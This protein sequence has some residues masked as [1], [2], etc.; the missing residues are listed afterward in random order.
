[1]C[2]YMMF[3]QR[4]CGAWKAKSHEHFFTR[5]KPQRAGVS[6]MAKRVRH[7]GRNT[8]GARGELDKRKVLEDAELPKLGGVRLRGCCYYPTIKNSEWKTRTIVLQYF[9]IVQMIQWKQRIIVHYLYST[10]R[11]MRILRIVEN[12]QGAD[13]RGVGGLCGML[14]W[15]YL[16]PQT[17]DKRKRLP[18]QNSKGVCVKTKDIPT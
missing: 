5:K 1:M 4:G 17:P 7:H 3:N 2:D 14:P 12:A 11:E 16:V 9:F 8:P 6:P 13:V 18:R 10:I 15:A